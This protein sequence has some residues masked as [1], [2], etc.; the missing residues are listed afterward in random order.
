MRSATVEGIEVPL[1]IDRDMFVAELGRQALSGSSLEDLF[2][3]AGRSLGELLGAELVKILALDEDR[4][5]L[6]VVHG[7]GWDP[8][9]VGRAAVPNDRAS[10][11]GYTLA[12]D[13]VVV[14][15]D[16]RCERRFAGPALLVEHGV[17]SGM[18]VPIHTRDGVYGV[19]GVHSRRPY[20]F[21]EADTHFLHSVANVLGSAI[22][23]QSTRGAHVGGVAAAITHDLNNVIQV[24][25]C[26]AS[27][28]RAQIEDPA[29]SEEADQI[30]ESAL[31]AGRFL[32][33]LLAFT[34]HGSETATRLDANA[35]I[36][37][38]LPLLRRVAGN[39]MTIEFAPTLFETNILIDPMAMEQIL[40]NL[41]TNARDASDAN[42]LISIATWCRESDERREVVLSIA[43]RGRGI[44]PE[45]RQRIFEPMFTTKPSG[46]G[47]GLGLAIVHALVQRA[48]GTI[49]VTSEPGIGTTFEL[50]FP[51]AA[52]PLD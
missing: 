34:R 42:G 46:K 47:T 49:S 25:S 39:A 37:Q 12:V 20:A 41:V 26:C 18:S 4:K 5:W 35:A 10:Q 23:C 43:D 15:S 14:T 40:L 24:I 52:R 44:P 9:V 38:T 1:V 29:L 45:L 48:G 36:K 7:V 13:T 51:A 32:Q 27:L 17:A 21:T 22:G 16:L 11:A 6:R 3:F 50:T 28:L 19:L 33:R 30:V 31:L 2:A 8:G